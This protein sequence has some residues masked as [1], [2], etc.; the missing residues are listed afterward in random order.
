MEGLEERT[1]GLTEYMPRVPSATR[2]AMLLIALG[3]LFG[4]AL[5]FVK[6][7][8]A[9]FSFLEY[10]GGGIFLVS[11]PAF[12]S[13]ITCVATKRQLKFR[14]M[15]FLSLVCAGLYAIFYLASVALGG[16][17]AQS[18][19]F[20]LIG[21]GLSFI[22]WYAIAKL[23]FQLRYS[24]FLFAILQLAYNA[25]FFSASKVIGL[26]SDTFAITLKFY[27]VSGIF[28]VA[29][30]A[31]FWLVN[32][33]IKRNFGISGID[34]LSMFL[35]QW[36]SSSSDIEEMFESVGQDV[37]TTT[38]VVVFEGKNAK[39]AF[40]VPNVH[41]GPIGNLGGSEFPR[42]ISNMM[43]A[44]HNMR[45][46]VFHGTA[47]H[48]FNPVSS[49]EVEKVWEACERA[50]KGM[51]LAPGR[52]DFEIGKS[53]NSR[54]HCL[55]INDAAFVGFTR[56][57]RT[58]EDVDF[59]IGMAISERIRSLGVRT[60]IVCDAHNA[61]IGEIMK[62]ESGN[63]IGFEY[64]DAAEDAVGKASGRSL[65]KFGAGFEAFAGFGEA[66]V[67]AN[68]LRCAAFDFG[69]SKKY[70][71]ML[72]DANG[73]TPGFRRELIGIVEKKTGYQCELY[74]T[75]THSINMIRGVL[76]PVGEKRTEELMGLSLKAALDAVDAV[77]PVKVGAAV[78]RFG[79]KVIGPR[80]ASEFV[81]TVNSIV[82]IAKIAVPVMLIGT[83]LLVL[84]AATKI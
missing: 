44:K 73:I 1:V 17:Y 58:T 29:L 80:Q 38:G 68:G 22:L 37:E 48:D 15:L 8:T 34:A 83:V 84:W 71:L 53:G 64:M 35:G 5:A 36:I 51:K 3:F 31:I 20:I 10:A 40:V 54:A 65:L 16:V 76:N 41:F 78:E 77:E 49:M 56:A 55:R 12:L 13:A 52:G 79:I 27:F 23:A 7:T 69:G 26:G 72:F 57:P 81:G 11:I 63:P 2:S 14:R 39:A 18:A 62:V 32:A 45:T 67:G 42:L 82:A 21:Y 24:A 43:E 75:D 19:N 47:T 59:S 61:E 70:L 60:P 33:P 25:L 4:I 66:G 6:G 50:L 28:L 74:T 9:P 30:Y 46:F